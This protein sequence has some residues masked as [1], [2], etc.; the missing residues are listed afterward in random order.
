MM[1]LLDAKAIK[2]VSLTIRGLYPDSDIDG[3]MQD[4][5][6]FAPDP[7]GTIQCHKCQRWV[8][9][10]KTVALHLTVSNVKKGSPQGN[11]SEPGLM[12]RNHSVQIV[13]PMATLPTGAT[14]QNKIAK[15]TGRKTSAINVNKVQYHSKVL[16]NQNPLALKTF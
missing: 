13:K 15:A 4:L 9:S 11:A 14:R 3:I 7:D 6:R 10:P 1:A 8:T 12:L 2:Q 5:D 16:V